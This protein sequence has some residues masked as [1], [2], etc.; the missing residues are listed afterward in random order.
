MSKS[1][2]CDPGEDGVKFFLGDKEGVLIRGDPTPR[3]AVRVPPSPVG[4]PPRG[5]FVAAVTERK[6]RA[7]G[8]KGQRGRRHRETEGHRG[9]GAGGLAMQ[10]KKHY[11][12]GTGLR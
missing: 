5:G 1:T 9:A 10:T 7:A 6:R 4:P 8:T 12:C 3:P 11:P 2:F